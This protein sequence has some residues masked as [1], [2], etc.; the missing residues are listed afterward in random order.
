MPA[1]AQPVLHR[2][3][4]PIVAAAGFAGDG[5]RIDR[6]RATGSVSLAGAV[7]MADAKTG[8]VQEASHSQ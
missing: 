8:A 4:E 1:S 5:C 6:E 3:A 7:S 2:A